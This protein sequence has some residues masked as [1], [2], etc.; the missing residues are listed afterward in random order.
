MALA[1]TPCCHRRRSHGKLASA[2]QASSRFARWRH[3]YAMALAWRSRATG[4]AR[5]VAPLRYWYGA[6]MAYSSH[7]KYWL[8]KINKRKKYIF[9]FYTY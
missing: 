9:M 7:T 6:G 2:R 3:D 4:M 8:K 5:P 1:S